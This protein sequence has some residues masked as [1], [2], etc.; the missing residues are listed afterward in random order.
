MRKD[1]SGFVKACKTC[2]T[3]KDDRHKEYGTAV[4]VL[5]ANYPGKRY[6]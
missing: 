2:A 1:I 5:V 3:K 6:N 4:G